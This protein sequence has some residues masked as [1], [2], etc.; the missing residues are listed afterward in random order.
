VVSTTTAGAKPLQITNDAKFIRGLTWLADSSGVIYATARA[1]TFPYLP[2]MALWE[3]RLDGGQRQVSTPEASYEQ[4]DLEASGLLSATRVRMR[5]DIWQYPFVAVSDS[6]ERGRQLTRQTGQ[7]STPTPSPDGREVA[8]LSDNGDHANIWATSAAGAPRQLTFENDP[9]VAIG[10]PAWSPDGQWIAYLSS[11]GNG[12]LVFGMWLVRPD[13]SDNHQVVPKALSPSW[14]ADGRWIYYVETADTSIKRV[15]VGGGA[16]ETVRTE[17]ARNVI[18]L[19]D[20]TLYYV[21][22]RALTDG[23]QQFEVHAASLD[24]GG[25]RVISEIPISRV[26]PWQIVNPALSP[27]GQ[28]LAI[29]LTDGFTTDIWAISTADGRMKQVTNFGGRPIFIARR[30]SWSPDGGSILA[31]I[32]E[33]DADVVLLDGLIKE[34]AR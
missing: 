24:G 11:K 30:L 5:Y 14:S 33:G 23:R 16:P 8:Y 27:D 21:V 9:N 4:P 22:D 1:S 12:G 17:P 10:L 28:W 32:G 13:G 15:A 34:D 3:A 7:V 25:A 18:G 26:P 6:V 31:A 20:S 29:P 19:H 2:P